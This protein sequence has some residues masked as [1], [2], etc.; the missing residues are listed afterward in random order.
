MC[1]DSKSE[2]LE[3]LFLARAKSV[4]LQ[5]SEPSKTLAL[6]K[7]AFNETYKEWLVLQRALIEKFGIAGEVLQP[8]P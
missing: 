5:P 6:R 4:P 2:G 7:N 8:M 3:S 1:V